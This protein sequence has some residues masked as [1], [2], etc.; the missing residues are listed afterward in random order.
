MT[1]ENK[2]L[3]E[4]QSESAGSEQP[5]VAENGMSADEKEKSG[6]WTRWLPAPVG[7]SLFFGALFVA[8]GLGLLICLL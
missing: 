8:V 5:A 2:K 7:Y 4:D 1:E 6:F 3:T